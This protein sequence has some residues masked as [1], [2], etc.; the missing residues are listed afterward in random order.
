[1][2]QAVQGSSNNSLNLL[3]TDSLG[4]SQLESDMRIEL[5]DLHPSTPVRGNQVAGGNTAANALSY[6]YVTVSADGIVRPAQVVA[7]TWDQHSAQA[8]GTEKARAHVFMGPVLM[9]R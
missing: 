1:L 7:G 4:Q 3:A 9:Q 2:D 6:V 5:T 8:A